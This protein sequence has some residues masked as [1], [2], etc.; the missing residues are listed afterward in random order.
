MRDYMGKSNPHYKH[1]LCKTRLYRIWRNMKVRCYNPKNRFFEFYGKR[2]IAICDEWKDNFQAFYD[3]AMS[4]GYADSLTIDRI[5]VNGNY[6]PENCRWVDMGTQTKNRRSNRIIDF[7][8]ERKTVT[9]WA[10]IFSINVDTLYSRLN[11]GLD[12]ETALTTPVDENK[13]RYK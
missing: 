3:W 6:S 11:K 10:D 12:V 5:D 9:E 8:G 7:R 13:R 2:G 4:N 1:G